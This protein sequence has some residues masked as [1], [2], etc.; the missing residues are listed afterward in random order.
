M[1]ASR[2]FSGCVIPEIVVA[3]HGHLWLWH[4]HLHHLPTGGATKTG[5]HW[6][7]ASATAMLLPGLNTI[8]VDGGAHAVDVDY[9]QIDGDNAGQP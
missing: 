9:L 2:F 7:L 1:F 8:D 5:D 4:I 3:F 6:E